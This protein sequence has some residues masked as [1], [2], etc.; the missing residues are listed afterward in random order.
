MITDSIINA[1][2]ECYTFDV[3]VVDG[4]LIR[5]R[6][7][8]LQRERRDNTERERKRKGERE[9]NIGHIVGTQVFRRFTVGPRGNDWETG[10]LCTLL[11]WKL[12][13]LMYLSLLADRRHLLFI[14]PEQYY[15]H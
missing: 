10:S 6:M 2:Q 12:P 7:A 14:V 15:L 4:G 3:G 5:G 9:Q 8:G 11:F 13:S 1:L